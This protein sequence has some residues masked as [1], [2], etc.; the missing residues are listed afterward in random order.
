M[1][2]DV[3]QYLQLI[4]NS[5]NVD[6]NF[7]S[8][9]DSKFFEEHWYPMSVEQTKNKIKQGI[10]YYTTGCFEEE[11]CIFRIPKGEEREGDFVVIGPYKKAYME[12]YELNER[13]KEQNLSPSYYHELE[14]YYNSIPMITNHTAFEMVICN[15]VKLLYAKEEVEMQ[16]LEN[17]KR[18]SNRMWIG[19]TQEER[20]V[21]FQL[22]E[23]R[24]RIEQEILFFVSQGNIEKALEF[25]NQSNRYKIAKRYKEKNRNY[26]NLLISFNTLC[27]KSVE[28]SFVHPV[29][30]DELST[31]FAK[32]IE[33]VCSET[34]ALKLKTQMIRKYCML[35][36][37]YS[38]KGY[39]P[40]IQK[41][42]N[43]IELNLVEELTL[44]VLAEKFS[45]NASYLSDVFK[46]EVGETLTSYVN[47][48]RI[49]Q[50]IFY[51]NTS[52]M[53]VQ[54]IATEVGVFDVNYFIK[55]FKKLVG[56][57]PREYRNS[58]LL[59]I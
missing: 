28:T 32:Q 20:T 23:E 54:E 12:R 48:K 47:H 36:K 11:N 44:K 10:L 7:V 9:G 19:T 50:A 45:V 53:Q 27:R 51:L 46:K 15:T 8:K 29:Y 37:N 59:K 34:E 16:F 25:L 39:S 43:Y 13:M 24:Y 1:K 42:I 52:Q 2:I 6:M 40:L 57:T 35:V 38:L 58:I 5:F 4:V 41:V 3:L 30:I 49:K 56:K 26:R 21:L 17:L 31:K 22:L 18:D 55:L 33:T 14:E